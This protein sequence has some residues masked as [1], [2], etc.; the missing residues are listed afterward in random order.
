MGLVDFVAGW[1]LGAKTGNQ[2]FD[3]VI[4]T[5]KGIFESKEFRDFVSAAR[6]HVA[7]SLQELSDLLAVD[8]R[9]PPG[10]DLV[11]FVRALVAR[12]EGGGAGGPW[13]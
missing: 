2:G 13:R 11:D 3:D 8:D 1:A 4:A 9:E 10:E 5:A 7:Y 12:R 6:S